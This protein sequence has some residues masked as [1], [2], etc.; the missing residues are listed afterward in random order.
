MPLRSV[1]GKYPWE[2]YE[3]SYS[4]SYGLN[5]TT[6][7]LQEWLWHLITNKGWYAIKQ[8]TQTQGLRKGE[9]ELEIGGRIKTI[10]T[11]TLLRSARILWRVLKTW[12]DLLSLRLW[13]KTISKSWCGKL[14][15][16]IIIIIII[17]IVFTSIITPCTFKVCLYGWL[18]DNIS[19]ASTWH[20][21][22]HKFYKTPWRYC[23]A[24]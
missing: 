22:M 2:R 23:A 5:T 14:T 1:S 7:V 9:E 8:R 4:P 20:T 12:G 24:T 10:Q 17:I 6:T 15:W 13:W 21:C 18:D 11:S 3:P 16:S 19:S